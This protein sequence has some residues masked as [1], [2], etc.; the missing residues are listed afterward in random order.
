M[1][2]DTRFAW[3]ASVIVAGA[4]AILLWLGSCPGANAQRPAAQSGGG[5]DMRPVYATAQDVADGM[6]LAE[7]TCSTCHGVRGVSTT[8]GVPNLAGQRAAYLYRELRAYQSGARGNDS[9]NGTVRFLSND[10]LTNVA[11]YY[12]SL[13]PAQPAPGGDAPVGPDPVLAG[14]TVA[15]VCAGCHGEAGVSKMPG[16]PS[17]IGQDPKYLV[18]S[19]TA[20]KTGQR[21][22]DV[23]KAMLAAPTDTDLNNVALYYAL[24]KPVRAQTPS[25][26]NQAAGQ[27]T[28]AACTGCHGSLGVSGNPA[29]PS[30][31]GQDAQYLAAALKAYKDGS[32]GDP[33]MKGIVATLDDTVIKDLAAFYAAQTPGAPNV[34]KPLSTADWVQRCDRCHGTNGNSTDP[35]LPALAAQR[36]EYLEKVLRDYRGGTRRSPEMAAMSDGL[37]DADIDGLAAWYAH[38]KPRAVVYVTVPPR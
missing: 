33:T 24:Q 18:G 28:A 27:A 35:R 8:A 15:N 12:A 16:I 13:D 20:Y 29:T 6:R 38:Q 23:M 25:P 2:S 30:L 34:R 1:R 26:G 5:D 7:A 22:N 3:V 10:A 21:K 9:M 17:L 32:R 36:V 11:A 4:L 31:A 14:K 19:M 37:T